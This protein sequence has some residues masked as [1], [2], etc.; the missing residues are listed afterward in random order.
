MSTHR[1]SLWFV[2]CIVVA[3]LL[4]SPQLHATTENTQ[5]VVLSLNGQWDVEDSI[6]PEQIPKTYSHTVPVPGLTHSATPAFA[7]VDQY[8]SRELILNP[9][10]KGLH[11]KTE[12]AQLDDASG[13]ARQ[14]RN[15]FWYRKT[16]T[17]PARNAVALLKVN[18][19]QFGT[20]V[21]LNGIRIGEHD[22]CFTAA[23]FDVTHA[24][25]W[26]AQNE[27]VLRIGAHPGVLPKNVSGGTD[28]EKNRW[29]PGIYDDVTL[30]AMNNPAIAVVQV[31]PRL[32]DSS[33]RVQTEL[34]NYSDHTITS[35]VR[36]EV[37][38]WKS[39]IQR[40]RSIAMKIEVP[41]GATRTTL[42]TVPIP[43]AHL[44]SP[45]D[46]FLYRVR[47]STSGDGTDTRFGMREFHFDTVTQRAYLNGHPYFLRGSNIALHRFFEDPDSGILPWD[48]AWLHRLLV[49][50]PKQMH[51]NAFRFCI[52]PV[53]D[54]WLEIADESGLL[55][56]NEYM[57]WTGGVPSRYDP[58]EMVTEYSEW[59]RDN[60]N[61]PSVAIWDATN[62]SVLPE[63]SSVVIPKVRSL[64]LSNRP[65]ENSFNAPVGPD[66]PVE[67]HEY[68]FYSTATNDD[69][70]MSTAFKMTDLERLVGPPANRPTSKSGHAMI[71][72]EYGW[73]WLNR[74]GTPTLLTQR[75]YPRLL[76]DK[77]TTENRF[78]L[79]AYLLG[80]ETEFWRAYRR[81]AGVLHFVY[82]SASDPNGYTSD[83]FHNVKTLEL[84]PH[85]MKAMEQAFNPLGVYLNFWQPTMKPSEQRDFTI[86]MV[87]DDDHQRSGTLSLVFFGTDGSRVTAENRPFALASLGAMSYTVTLNAPDTPGT[88]SLQAIAAPSDDAAHPTVSTR[89]V[90]VR[91]LVPSKQ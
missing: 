86:A 84:E 57:V 4:G 54:R 19:A 83:S 1:R 47:T 9:F 62:E 16:F 35:K 69:S 37:F 15:Y 56:E 73:L 7:D 51:W 38:D 32:G 63:F 42:Q 77:D 58:A 70:A 28:L 25:H 12:V 5:R 20:V 31:E 39:G 6:G 8:Q 91:S 55:I 27:L 40:S 75:L 34:H 87:N 59:M 89:N 45:E 71:L 76:G 82:L 60:W 14:K 17:A 52:G 49:E 29:T 68:L 21:Y 23:Y 26:N 67:D 11:F 64:D 80:G 79:G 88:Y 18:K 48:E 2:Y 30:L 65:W 13:I 41:A 22:P 24:I 3:F 78:A 36:Q 66:D 53:P 50:I 46:P 43:G 72:N 61:H 44:W 90:I 85:F 10:W 81:Y 33:I 74:D